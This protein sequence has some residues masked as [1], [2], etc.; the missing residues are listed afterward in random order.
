MTAPGPSPELGPETLAGRTPLKHEDK[1]LAA[2]LL[3]R[4]R[5]A[6]A[7]FVARYTDRVYSYVCSRLTPNMDDA[8]DLV[9]DVFLA[10]WKA[11][12]SFHGESTLGSWLLG[13]ARHKIQDYYRTRLR[14]PEPLDDVNE[15]GT[16]REEMSLLPEQERAI[17]ERQTR[18][19]T[20][21]VLAELP[22]QY[23][24]ALRWR[25]WEKCPILDMAARAGKTEKA[26][27]RLLARARDQFR[28]R[29]HDA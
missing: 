11:L 7:E 23:R 15:E 10:A 6:T 21:K 4:D 27:E 2:A 16:E 28:R 8:D 17:D 25:Y 12:P 5:K 14:A 29:W 22:E 3:A 26:M 9:Q 24:I 20:L 19:R 13:I 1:Q 18:E